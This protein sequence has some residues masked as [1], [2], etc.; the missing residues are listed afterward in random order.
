MCRSRIQSHEFVIGYGGHSIRGIFV[1]IIRMPR[2]NVRTRNA[3]KKNMGHR[4]KKRYTKGKKKKPLGKTQA[5]A[6]KKMIVKVLDDRI[7]DKFRLDTSFNTMLGGW[8]NLDR[9]VSLDITPS[10]TVGTGAGERIGNK[11]FMKGLKLQFRYQPCERNVVADADVI[12][13]ALLFTQDP[14]PQFPSMRVHIFKIVEKLAVA[15][16]P[17]QMRQSLEVKYRPPGFWPQDK[18]QDPDDDAVKAIRTL[19]SFTLPTKYKILTTA[20]PSFSGPPIVPDRIQMIAC[21]LVQTYSCYVKINKKTEI[22]NGDNKDTKWRY[23][24]FCTDFSFWTNTA[25]QVQDEP[26]MLDLRKCWL[27]EDA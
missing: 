23:G 21:P 14:V 25:S 20:V 8:S 12:T 3:R 27:Y 11:V 9:S 19:K 6:V 5:R 18:A 24:V 22:S 2:A 16:T 13:N 17:G 4:R 10:L 26:K 7:E 15:L 1:F